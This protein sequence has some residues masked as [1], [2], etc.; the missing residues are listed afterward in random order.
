METPGR[1]FLDALNIV[2]AVRIGLTKKEQPS[3]YTVQAIAHILKTEEVLTVKA[4][5][6][7]S[8]GDPVPELNEQEHAAF[9]MNLQK[10]I[11]LSLEQRKLLTHSQREHCLV[12]LE[13]Q[14]SQGQKS[15]HR[16]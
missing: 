1:R 8:V 11:L 10:A 15:G 6:F 14:Y 16:T 7:I 5:E 2:L 9:L 12:E 4:R 3:R 13:K